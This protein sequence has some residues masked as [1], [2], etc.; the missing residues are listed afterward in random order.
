MDLKNLL[1]GGAAA[2]ADQRTIGVEMELLLL[3]GRKHGSGHKG[4]ARNY[5]GNGG[6]IARRNT[7]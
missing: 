6:S 2:A 3:A 1:A 4:C 7:N 5:S